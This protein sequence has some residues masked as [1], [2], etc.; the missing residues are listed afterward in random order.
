MSFP[1]F[2]HTFLDLIDFGF[3]ET[4][5]STLDLC[6]NLPAQEFFKVN[7]EHHAVYHP[8]ELS[9]LSAITAPHQI[10]LDPYCQRLRSERYHIPM[11]RNAFALLVQWL[12]GAALDEEWEAGLHSAPGRAKEAIR[13]IVNSRIDLKGGS[14][15]FK[16]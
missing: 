4:G 8:T 16:C 2:A 14:K 11:S 10:L 5:E 1:L 3:G 7:Q 15:D 12:S 13:A 9:Y 6:S